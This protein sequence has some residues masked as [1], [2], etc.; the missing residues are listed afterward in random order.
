MRAQAGA[1]HLGNRRLLIV[2]PGLSNFF[3]RIPFIRDFF[4]VDLYGLR[5]VI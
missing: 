2:P 4:G 3:F 5:R 1:L